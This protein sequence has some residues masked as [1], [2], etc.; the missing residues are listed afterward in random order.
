MDKDLILV[1]VIEV[2]SSK[3]TAL[4]ESAMEARDAATNE[5]SKSEN[6]YDTRGL[7]ASY[8][9]GAQAERAALLKK[10]IA[11]LKKI[12]VKNFKSSEAVAIHAMVEVQ[13]EFDEISRYFLLPKGGG[14][15]IRSNSESV[16]VITLESPIAKK[17]IGKF[18]DDNFDFKD[19]NYQIIS[20][21]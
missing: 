13:N 16:T 15:K 3:F 5:E 4:V 10:D 17:L 18:V 11:L 21:K 14:T 6:K 20:V 12:V 1:H 19:Q 2:L 7:E 8:L 9:A